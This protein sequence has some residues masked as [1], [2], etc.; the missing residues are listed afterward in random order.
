MS[1]MP[2]ILSGGLL[3]CASAAVAL[4]ASATATPVK[5][6][7]I[8]SSQYICRLCGPLSIAAR[9]CRMAPAAASRAN[10]GKREFSAERNGGVGDTPPNSVVAGRRRRLLWRQLTDALGLGNVG[11]CALH[12]PHPAEDNCA[13]SV[14]LGR[15]RI[16]IDRQIKIDQC[17]G[18]IS[19][20][21]GQTAAISIVSGV[22]H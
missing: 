15:I 12:I 3:S 20:A 16:E 19:A 11:K 14:G 21:I 18:Q 2:P 8:P 7:F 1:R 10:A 6:R 13:I 4:S 22:L 5:I 17:H 9:S